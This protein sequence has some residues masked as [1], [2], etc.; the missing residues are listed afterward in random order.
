MRAWHSLT[1]FLAFSVTRFVMGGNRAD[2][3]LETVGRGLAPA[4]RKVPLFAEHDTSSTANA[5]PLLP[6]EK[7]N[8]QTDVLF[9]IFS[10]GFLVLFFKKERIFLLKI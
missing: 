1:S 2:G 6:L 9:I 5:V 10:K 7:A 3:C 4:A 8:V